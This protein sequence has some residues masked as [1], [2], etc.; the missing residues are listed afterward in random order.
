MQLTT[1]NHDYIIDI[2]ELRDHMHILNESFTNPCIV[3]VCTMC[4][5]C[6]VCSVYVYCLCVCVRVRVRVCVCVSLLQK[7]QNAGTHTAQLVCETC[8]C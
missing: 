4:C 6:S 7:V 8:H 3:K 1:R 2:L 5:V